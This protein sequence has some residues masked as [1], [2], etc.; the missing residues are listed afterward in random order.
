MS[1]NR[2][3]LIL[4]GVGR[5]TAQILV[6]LLVFTA[7][8]VI[9]ATLALRIA[10]DEEELKELALEM[11]NES[12]Y[13]EVELGRVYLSPMVGLVIR[14]LRVL[15]SPE[16]DRVPAV[17]IDELVFAYD[18][19]AF[20]DKGVLEISACEIGGLRLH[21]VEKP[22]LGWNVENLAPPSEE[23][24]EPEPFTWGDVPV[25]V[26]LRRVGVRELSL[27]VEDGVAADLGGV[28]LELF[29]VE[30]DRRL[31]LELRF[32]KDPGPVS[33]RMGPPE[34]PEL[35]A[36]V[37]ELGFNFD[38]SLERRGTA[39]AVVGSYYLR[40]AGAEVTAPVPLA[41]AGE[42]FAAG[43]FS[44]DLDRMRF[45]LSLERLSLGDYLRVGLELGAELRGDPRAVVRLR[46]LFV[47]LRPLTED[48]AA[49]LPPLAASGTLDAAAT[50]VVPLRGGIKT[51][52]VETELELRNVA[53]ALPAADAELYGLD[54]VLSASGDIDLDDPRPVL[55]IGA[56]V[57]LLSARQGG[58]AASG[59]ELSAAGMVDTATMRLAGMNLALG[60]GSV[61]GEID[62][63]PVAL[64]DLSLATVVDADLAAGD[65]SGRDLSLRLGEALAWDGSFA[66]R[67]FAAGGL[68]AEFNELYALPERL[69]ALVPPGLV[70]L[71]EV[72]PYGTLRLSGE[73]AL[74]PG[75]IGAAD[76]VQM[77]RLVDT[78]LQL[79]LID[80]GVATPQGGVDGLQL[81]LGLSLA[82]GDGSLGLDLSVDEV[83]AD[84]GQDLQGIDLHLAGELWDLEEL[85]L[86]TL[87]LDVASLDT[88]VEMHGG[89]SNLLGTPEVALLLDARVGRIGEPL[90]VNTGPL[91][92]SGQLGLELEITGSTAGRRPL[93][94]DGR[95][96]FHQLNA[97]Q[98][99]VFR[100]EGLEGELPIDQ[101]LIPTAPLPLP[102]SRE[103]EVSPYV[104]RRYDI[105]KPFTPE[106]NLYIAQVN[107][108]GQTIEDLELT[109]ELSGGALH[110]WRLGL[111]AL[112]GDIRGEVHLYLDR[113]KPRYNTRLVFGGV[114]LGRLVE[115]LEAD[116][117]SAINGD[118]T[119]AGEGFDFLG[120]FNVEGS[121]NV[122]KIGR[123]VVDRLL[124]FIDPEESDPSITSVRNLLGRVGRQP[125]LLKMD[126][127]NQKLTLELHIE[128]TGFSLLSLF[129]SFVD[130]SRIVIPRIPVGN[131]LERIAAEAATPG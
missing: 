50:V 69:L 62:G 127:K 75:A 113:E 10:Y 5:W 87:T 14:D 25:R 36:T 107:A 108:G 74:A 84:V 65:V 95:V 49:V 3:L 124:L 28:S 121:V 117:T 29:G 20:L 27:L 118:L 16:F 31:P 91:Q 76:P 94:L 79:R 55:D 125:K 110:I 52:S 72:Y 123:Q 77:A 109:W 38:V 40:A 22:G 23:E 51:V 30:T 37:D 126:L 53:A 89:V 83:V 42:L 111:S 43:D 115:G 11:I 33:L 61:S 54:A 85:T 15:S 19:A 13:G 60:V 98:G 100:V 102:G 103:T 34:A 58:Y 41:P 120:D 90:A 122:T 114:N 4:A 130:I 131:I 56:E 32:H 47:D 48:F 26:R 64:G 8:A 78:D 97:S 66:M 93:E 35:A 70:E 86:E 46:E 128:N 45:G 2:L 44:L 92:V 9:I 80:S 68:R 59:V 17:V 6:G 63:A 104:E 96:R 129:A 81:S 1:D 67:G 71:P 116:E 106:P 119:L 73:L 105:L 112:E 57:G 99:A 18:L 7:S 82:D 39:A 12:L 21:L 88:H 24:P 101:G